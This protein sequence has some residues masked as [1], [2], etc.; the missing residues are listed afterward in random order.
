MNSRD[1]D[2]SKLKEYAN[3]LGLKVYIKP[4]NRTTGDAEYNSGTSITLFNR[5]RTTKTDMILSLLH[6]LGHHL[7]WIKGKSNK[8]TTVA[9]ELLNQGAMVGSRNDIPKKYRKMILQVE[10]AG[11]KYMSRIHKDLNLELPFYLVKYQQF[12][13]IFDY[14]FLY[15]HGRFSTRKEALKT[16]YKKG[17][18]GYFKKRYG[19]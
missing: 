4:Y 16:I 14:Q 9:F 18:K 15:D 8:E 10:K 12:I 6:E 5:T 11:I 17:V 19:R 2:I 13:D 1:R 7:D 3:S